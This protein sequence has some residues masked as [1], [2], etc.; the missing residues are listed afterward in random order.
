MKVKLDRKHPNVSTN[1]VVPEYREI[2][3]EALEK[4]NETID[5]SKYDQNGN[6]FL[7][8]EE[9]HIFTILAGYNQAG[10]SNSIQP[11]NWG[12]DSEYPVSIDG[13]SF[14]RYSMVGEKAIEYNETLWKDVEIP[15]NLGVIA[16]EF[17]HDL[18]LPDLHKSNVKGKGLGMTSL[19][20]YGSYGAKK[21]EYRGETPVGLD[22]YSKML[23]GV[24][25]NEIEIT[26]EQKITVDSNNS[27]NQSIY[28]IKTNNPDEYFLIDNRQL[29]GYDSGMTGVLSSGVGIYK[30]NENADSYQLTVSLLEA[31]EGILGY[32][33]LKSG[34]TT[35][36]DPFFYKGMG[37][38]KQPQQTVIDRDTIPS[39]QLGDDSYPNYSF[40]IV[41]ENST[42][43][44]IIVKNIVP[45]EEIKFDPNY[46]ELRV[47]DTLKLNPIISPE[48]ATQ[49]DFIWSSSDDS[50]VTVS[51]DG[52]IT[53]KSEGTA[54]IVIKTKDSNKE[55]V[56]T[57][58]IS[59]Q[60]EEDDHGDTGETAT[61]IN[62]Y[63]EV[64]GKINSDT[65][66][67]VFELDLPSGSGKT[68]VLESMNGYVSRWSIQTNYM[69]WF[70]F[71]KGTE[72]PHEE[73]ETYKTTY[74]S[75]NTLDKKIRFFVDKT[76]VSK[77]KTYKF[78]VYVL[79]KG[80]Q[81][82]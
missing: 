55:A 74:K 1:N 20:S 19:M 11:H 53:A 31:D 37:G 59:K 75:E 45:V 28:K 47:N 12:F 76:L 3:K 64:T 65:D 38:H 54:K 29:T 41:S 58:K 16:H 18:G 14:Y 56:S 21:G 33:N 27:S 79:Q 57:I 73:G 36:M 66:I 17:G 52:I 70:D 68:I 67:D 72:L 60:I 51:K 2:V 78:K 62:E 40:E 25:V 63:E 44:D 46:I 71:Y 34:I 5:Y 82:L 15:V 39:T 26:K 61:K 35:N 7:E 42:N 23:L 24:P 80:E 43:M 77:G 49:K 22:A 32:S 81:I 50:I 69:Y 6:G 9:L 13:V 10:R 4:L 8:S 48:N 30:V